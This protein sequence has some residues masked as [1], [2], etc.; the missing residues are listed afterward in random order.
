MNAQP[1]TPVI[2]DAPIIVFDAM[3]VLC[4][5]NA[6]FILKYDRKQYF[7]L[8]S[9]QEAVGEALYRRNGID[10][11]NPETLIVVD[12]DKVLRNSDAVLEIYTRIGW[13]WK[14]MGLFRL[15]PR[16]LRD[17]VYRLIARNRYRLFGQRDSC[18]L[19]TPEQKARVL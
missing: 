1:E 5:S 14:I 3:C 12:G 8:A 4:S 2:P 18:W 7:F 16:A 10:P 15:V 19:P 6:Q 17:P 9:M 13:P 11:N